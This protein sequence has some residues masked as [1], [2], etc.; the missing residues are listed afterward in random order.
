VAI[1]YVLSKAPYVFPILGGRKVEHLISNL[2]A[3]EITLSEAQIAELEGAVK[4]DPGFPGTMIVR[5]LFQFLFR[6]YPSFYLLH[7]RAA[8][9]VFC[10]R[11]TLG[12]SVPFRIA[13]DAYPSAHYTIPPP[14]L[15][16]PAS[17]YTL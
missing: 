8:L 2:T 7:P 3:L 12:V 13:L 6:L 14:F 15:I 17:P 9:S 16:L 5:R 1:A 11:C 10:A 4:F